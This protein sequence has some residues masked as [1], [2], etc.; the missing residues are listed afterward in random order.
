MRWSSSLVVELVSQRGSAIPIKGGLR[1][2]G[3]VGDATN[4]GLLH[5]QADEVAGVVAQTDFSVARVSQD[6]IIA[7]V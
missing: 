5:M 2:S 7:R 4:V 1:L 3:K 6:S